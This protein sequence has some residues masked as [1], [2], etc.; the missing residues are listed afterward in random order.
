M[1]NDPY[2]IWFL[3]FRNQWSDRCNVKIEETL[4]CRNDI[5]VLGWEFTLLCR[6]HGRVDV[7][8]LRI[9]Q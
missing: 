2:A 7:L 8:V 5:K 3:P 1:R 4:I 9:G 6:L